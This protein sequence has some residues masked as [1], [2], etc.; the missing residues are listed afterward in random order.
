VPK[1]AVSNTRSSGGSAVSVLPH[2]TKANIITINIILPI[3][4]FRNIKISLLK[5]RHKQTSPEINWGLATNATI[6]QVTAD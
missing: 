1:S 5:N 6:F 2:A 4:L 3:S